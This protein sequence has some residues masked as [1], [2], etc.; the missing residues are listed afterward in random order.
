M[1]ASPAV[2][3]AYFPQARWDSQQHKSI[4][5]QRCTPHCLSTINGYIATGLTLSQPAAIQSH[6]YHQKKQRSVHDVSSLDSDPVSC[7][8]RYRPTCTIRNVPAIISIRRY[9][10]TPTSKNVQPTMSVSGR[11]LGQSAKIR[12]HFYQQKLCSLRCQALTRSACCDTVRAIST[13]NNMQPT[14]PG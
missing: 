10:S 2:D 5:S 4:I 6:F 8:L 13:T 1:Q 14:M 9:S 3:A 7:T 11:L 12:F